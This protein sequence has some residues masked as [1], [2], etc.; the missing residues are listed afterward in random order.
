MKK[1]YYALETEGKRGALYLYDDITSEG[2]KSLVA[3][4]TKMDVDVLHV[5]INSLGGDVSGGL[6][7]YNALVRHKARV[8][9][10][11]DG[12]MASAATIP[13]CAG[14]VRVVSRA[15]SSLIHHAWTV[16][17]GNAKDFIKQAEDLKVIT[18][19]SIEVYAS[20]MN[21]SKEEI[22]ALMDEERWLTPDEMVEM[23]LA[24][25]IK[26][27]GEKGVQQSVK[28]RVLDV[29]FA[30]Q[31]NGSEGNTTA[32]LNEDDLI[33]DEDDLDEGSEGGNTNDG[34]TDDGSSDDG[35]TPDNTEGEGENSGDGE[36]D[37][38][39]TDEG[40]NPDDDETKDDDGVNPQESFVKFFNALLK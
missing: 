10:H 5:F 29:I 16:G 35:K 15:S 4:L 30:S 38:G 26:E 34:S 1:K 19:A 12:L 18:Q 22:E 3:E 21:K 17:A 40:E 6:A 20:I 37:E 2:T 24:T 32:N 9:T 14:D 36:S 28:Q 25:K 39:N 11:N 33:D 27:V 7:I 23:G 8:I 31:G 13:F